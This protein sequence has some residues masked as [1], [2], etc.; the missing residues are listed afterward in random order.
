MNEVQIESKKQ[1]VKREKVNDF[2]D[3]SFHKNWI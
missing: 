2:T 3:A 1:Q